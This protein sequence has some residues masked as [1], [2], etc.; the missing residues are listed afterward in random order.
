[1][2]LE[3][4]SCH[5]VKLQRGDVPSLLKEKEKRKHLIIILY[6]QRFHIGKTQAGEISRN[7]ETIRSKWESGINVLQK[8]SFF[9]IRGI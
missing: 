6:L 7:K 5:C 3:G 2:C 4:R 8:R 9:K 1:M